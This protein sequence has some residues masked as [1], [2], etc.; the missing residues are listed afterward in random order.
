MYCIQ[1]TLPQPRCVC[2]LWPNT[3]LKQYGILF[4]PLELHKRTSTG[5]L[6]HRL[7]NTRGQT[8]H[9]LKNEQM[10][11]QFGS[12][13][14][15]YPAVD[16]QTSIQLDKPAAN[17]QLLILDGTWQQAQKMIRQSSWLNTLPRVSIEVEAPS[18]YNLRRNQ[19]Q[20]GLSTLEALAHCL[21]AQGRS[22]SAQKLLEFL[23]LFQ[24]AYLVARESG[25]FNEDP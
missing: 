15:V 25:E 16:E 22:Q 9:R 24:Q 4:H 10:Q 17:D 7:S 5:R 6:L 3:D 23:A 8:W 19:K 2:S 20:Q 14:L 21:F 11:Q 18:L 1:C 13:K 12:Y